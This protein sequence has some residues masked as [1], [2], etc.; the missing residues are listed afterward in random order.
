MR[1]LI[2]AA[3]IIVGNGDVLAGPSYLD[4]EDGRVRGAISGD[5]AGVPADAEVVDASSLTLMP[6]MMDLHLH[7]SQ[8]NF[9][10]FKNYRV[11][12]FETSPQLQLL[13]S[14]LHA[15]MC[16][17]MG[18][19]TL[20]DTGAYGY[21]GHLTAEMVALREAI[22]MG[23]HAGPRLL[24]TGWAIITGAHLDIILPRS[25]PRQP[26]VT[27]DGPW[28]IRK[29]ARQQLRTGADWVKASLSGG[30]G[31]DN[32][33][34]DIRNMT[35]EEADALADEA[36]A[37]GKRACF[38]CFT[39]SSQKM[40]MR[41]GANTLEH[42]VFTDDEAIKMMLDHDITLTPTLAHRTDHAI[43]L[44]RTQGTSDFTLAKMKAIQK[45]AMDTFQRLHTAGVRMACGTDTQIDPEMGA[46]AAEL[47][48]YVEL[49]MTPAEA[50][51]TATTNA[52]YA[53]GLHDELG[54]LE[55]GKHADLLAISGNPL[56]DITILQEKE[57]IQL[58]IKGGK[59]YVDRRPGQNE[60]LIHDKDWAWTKPY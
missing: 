51:A 37:F 54:T 11:A 59:I 24:V 47:A 22:E 4:I 40:A 16:M 13:Y 25:F 18:F 28:E 23:I 19:T 12:L 3:R 36:H 20:R 27:A 35:Q 14:L 44:R 39:P 6:G 60:R 53:L 15:Q 46:Q 1:K 8:F 57:K 42:C 48:T 55:P 34:P 41:A 5:P 10:T 58:V 17:E 49:G 50:I 21:T 30:G 9:M 7:L 38:H 45:H 31:T 56:D 33:A 43:E 52:A 26:G 32:E 29:L 2:K